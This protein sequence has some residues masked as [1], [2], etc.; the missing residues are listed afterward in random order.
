MQ[1]CGR[2]QRASVVREWNRYQLSGKEPVTTTMTVAFTV[3]GL[4]LF[5][6]PTHLFL[7]FSLSFIHQSIKITYTKLPNGNRRLILINFL[8]DQL[9]GTLQLQETHWREIL[10]QRL[11]SSPSFSKRNQAF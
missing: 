5:C 1:E 4:S 2:S 10:Q 8:I 6:T 11:P 3:T 7:C 9:Y